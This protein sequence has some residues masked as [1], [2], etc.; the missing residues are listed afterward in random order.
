[1]SGHARLLLL[2]VFAGPLQLLADGT[3]ETWEQYPTRP[4]L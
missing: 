4:E 2:T 1:M 3:G